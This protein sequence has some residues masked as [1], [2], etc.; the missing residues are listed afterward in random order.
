M[1]RNNEN[2]ITY[3][4]IR[5]RA[6][7]IR[8]LLEDMG[9]PYRNEAIDIPEW[10]KRKVETPFG[11][12][13]LYREGDYEIAESNAIM[14]FLARRYDLYGKNENEAVLCDILQ[15]VLH[16]GVE[17]FATLMW[18]RNF[19]EE[20]DG[21]IEKRLTPMLV[22][23]QRFL[24]HKNDDTS[25]WVGSGNTF[26]D[27]I[28]YVYLDMARALAIDVVQQ[29]PRLWELYR[30]VGERPRLRDY[31]NSDRRYPTLTMPMAYFGNTPET[32]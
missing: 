1:D 20:Q 14:R 27:Y 22:N 30:T 10:R 28:G 15:E 8:L 2:T 26:V 19:S 29:F 23:L 17:Q 32:S 3:F 16:D 25:H 21:F 9:V 18:N 6:E 31:L 7:P 11:R 4:P 12:L 13:P 5:G 24:E